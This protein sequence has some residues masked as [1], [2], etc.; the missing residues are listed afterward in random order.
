MLPSLLCIG[1]DA[2]N[3]GTGIAYEK[4]RTL[5]EAQC[6]LSEFGTRRRRSYQTQDIVVK[7]LVRAAKEVQS[8]GGLS[9]TSNVGFL[10]RTIPYTDAH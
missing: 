8:T 10:S 6:H 3:I 2:W 5:L 1:V 4:A 9:G 7:A